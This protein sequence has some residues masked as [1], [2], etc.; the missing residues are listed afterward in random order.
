M[1]FRPFAVLLLSSVALFGDITE[2][3]SFR[4]EAGKHMPPE[5]AAKI[6]ETFATVME[7]LSQDVQIKGSRATVRIGTFFSISDF[8]GALIT[9]LDRDNRRYATVSAQEYRR[10]WKDQHGTAQS[11]AAAPQ[12]GEM[13]VDGQLRATG[14]TRTLHGI[15]VEER[16]VKL[17]LPVSTGD[18]M[19]IVLSLWYP[20]AE[21]KAHNPAI[22]ELQRYSERA[23]IPDG[24]V[25]ELTSTM[26][27][28]VGVKGMDKLLGMMMEA[29]LHLEMRAGYIMPFPELPPDVPVF[30]I[31]QELTELSTAPI[32]DSVFAV[33][34][35]FGPAP[36][37][38]VLASVSA[39]EK[40]PSRPAV[41]APVILDGDEDP[42]PAKP[43]LRRR[44]P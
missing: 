7:G 22:I 12:R 44:K 30:E 21:A 43:R 37:A 26:G 33:P 17:S 19:K 42:D 29:G 32:D 9:I 5:I 13:R 25:T 10:A 27:S 39:S 38:E 36:I 11:Q 28:A 18:S 35:D 24:F 34:R 23:Y 16:Q 3:V 4:V 31:V 15:E 8:D 41:K 2:K 20:T 14:K 6:A 1:Y 40:T